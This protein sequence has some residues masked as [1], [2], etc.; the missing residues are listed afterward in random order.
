MQVARVGSRALERARVLQPAQAEQQRGQRLGGLVVQL[1]R[2]PAALLLLHGDHL[3]QQ[4]RADLL[5]VLAI[6][7]VG[8]EAI[9]V[10][11]AV[12][13][14][15]GDGA[16]VQPD[17]AAV[18]VLRAVL[19][20]ERAAALEE[21]GKALAHQRPVVG[22]H[23]REP[24]VGAGPTDLGLGVAAHPLD[25]R[26]DEQ[27]VALAVDQPRHVGDVVEERA[28]LLLAGLQRRLGLLAGGD[29]DL[30][31]AQPGALEGDAVAQPDHA[32]VG[33]QHAVLVDVVAAGGDLGSA[34]GQHA[35]PI[36]G[37]HVGAP[38]IR[39]VHPLL[40]GVAEESLGASTGEQHPPGGDVDFRHDRIH[41]PQQ[42]AQA[43]LGGFGPGP[44]RALGGEEPGVV[45]RDRRL[46]GERLQQPP[47]V[48]VE[49]ATPAGGDGER[50]DRLAAD[51]QRNR[52][53]R[54]VARPGEAG[55]HGRRV[56]QA[57]IVQHVGRDQRRALRHG[58]TR[59]PDAGRHHHRVGESRG[60]LAGERHRDEVAGGRLQPVDDD[61]AGA[62]QADDVVGD[63]MRDLAGI[64]R[65]GERLA[66]RGQ[67][68]G[69][70]PAALAVGEQPRALHRQRGRRG[71]R[72]ERLQRVGVR[73]ARP[74]TEDTEHTRQSV[75][76]RQRDPDE[77]A[78]PLAAQELR[79]AR[80]RIGGR[81][82]DERQRARHRHLADQSLADREVGPQAAV[83]MGQR[84]GGAPQHET[85]AGQEPDQGEA[86]GHALG[87]GRGRRGQDVGEAERGRGGPRQLEERCHR[88]CRLTD[89]TGSRQGQ[90]GARW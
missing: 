41:A 45:Q 16:V 29:V 52:H 25:V 90:P 19:E 35:L 40:D 66:H 56:A 9:G 81:L 14:V 22:M 51:Q 69:G 39:L 4:Q 30:E 82:V 68:L 37:M 80:A 8:V 2:D 79:G 60:A 73:T 75:A 89:E 18:P 54:P 47:G 61:V 13:L 71:Q 43:V 77:R 50:A 62:E 23:A 27:R 34:E 46:V 74:A 15:G 38:E 49:H 63:E 26:A 33:A 59:P 83:R 42:V 11:D 64:E 84:A 53:D 70:A 55:A 17:P 78:H 21:R 5:A 28:V 76:R 7:D 10:A 87:G 6:G 57:R 32:P 72:A 24:A 1:A 86:V 12:L 3:V 65:M 85:V 48:A 20:I 44:G 36:V 67:R 88:A 58:K 31:A